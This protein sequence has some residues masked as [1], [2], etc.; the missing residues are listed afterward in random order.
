M[1]KKS[2][3]ETH[4]FPRRLEESKRVMEKYPDRIPVI[5]EKTPNSKNIPNIDRVKFLVPKDI[6]VSQFTFIIRKR[7]NI[8]AEKAIFV[9]VNNT[10]PP[11]SELM[12]N[13]YEAHK[14]E[15]G[16]LYMKYSGE[17]TFG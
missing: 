1:P 15:D 11:S 9:F 7:I 8:T 12:S 10:L 16:F 17:N 13:I 3:I 2:F 4:P 5:M 6:A 14:N